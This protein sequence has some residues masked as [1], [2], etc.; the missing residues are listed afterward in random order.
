VKQQSHSIKLDHLRLVIGMVWYSLDFLISTSNAY[1]VYANL[2]SHLIDKHGE[3]I[4][5]LTQALVCREDDS[6]LEKCKVCLLFLSQ[7]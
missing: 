7:P 1:F 2:G 6:D 4:I 3:D 5:G